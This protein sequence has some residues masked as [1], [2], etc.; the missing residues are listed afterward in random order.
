MQTRDGRKKDGS[1]N[2]LTKKGDVVSNI[3]GGNGQWLDVELSDWK[4]TKKLF[5][6]YKSLDFQV[7]QDVVNPVKLPSQI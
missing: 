5:R 4:N 6:D 7:S 2:S 3:D 1:G